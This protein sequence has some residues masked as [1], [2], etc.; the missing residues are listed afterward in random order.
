MADAPAKSKSKL[1]TKLVGLVVILLVGFFLL[2]WAAEGRGNTELSATFAENFVLLAVLFG[3]G[4][5]LK[6][7]FFS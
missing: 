2:G 1:E 5:W 4:L 3:G 6:K 7:K